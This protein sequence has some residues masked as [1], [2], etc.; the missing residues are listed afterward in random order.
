MTLLVRFRWPLFRTLWYGFNTTILTLPYVLMCR[1]SVNI[2]LNTPG[3][4]LSVGRGMSTVVGC[5]LV[6][7]TFPG[8]HFIK[9][10]YNNYIHRRPGP[11]KPHTRNLNTSPSQQI[12]LVSWI[13]RN[14][15]HVWF[16]AP[17]DSEVLVDEPAFL[18]ISQTVCPIGR[19]DK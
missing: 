8:K 15:L 3:K 7:E 11:G 6:Q 19:N 14:T 5:F 9:L 16:W 13:A 4:A 1:V 17:I 2:M 10:P 18:A 12:R